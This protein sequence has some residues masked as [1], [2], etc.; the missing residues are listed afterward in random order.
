MLEWLLS[1]HK[2]YSVQPPCGVA[3]VE[4]IPINSNET[5]ILA[6]K[7]FFMTTS[8]PF[9]DTPISDSFPTLFSTDKSYA[10]KISVALRLSCRYLKLNFVLLHNNYVKSIFIHAS[11]ICGKGICL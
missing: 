10:G 1:D 9:R 3:G 5:A 4:S 6:I 11:I 7:N 8:G 2:R